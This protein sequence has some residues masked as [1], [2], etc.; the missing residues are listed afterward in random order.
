MGPECLLAFERKYLVKIGYVVLVDLV[1]E[2]ELRQRGK[3]PTL[4]LPYNPTLT[5]PG[6]LA[7][8]CVSPGLRF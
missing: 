1:Q 8:P 2:H 3:N 7:I 4:T 6:A 5:L